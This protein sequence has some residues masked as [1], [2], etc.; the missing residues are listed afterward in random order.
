MS[1]IKNILSSLPNSAGVYQF[2]SLAGKVIYVGK[3]KNLKS[4]V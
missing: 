3:S 2:L 4:R 1:E